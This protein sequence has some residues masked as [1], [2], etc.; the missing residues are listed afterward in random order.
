MTVL[1][2]RGCWSYTA[3]GLV[4]SHGPVDAGLLHPHTVGAFWLF[5]AA[6]NLASATDNAT[7]GDSGFFDRAGLGCWHLPSCD[8]RPATW[9]WELELASERRTQGCWRV[10]TG[11]LLE[12]RSVLLFVPPKWIPSTAGT[13]GR[14]ETETANRHRSSQIDRRPQTTNVLDKLAKPSHARREGRH[15]LWATCLLVRL[16]V[17]RP[18]STSA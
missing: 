10:V 1:R 8:M 18:A 11:T 14:A 13:G 5:A 16:R 7:Q 15:F 9:T 12:P 17:L 4:P 2:R 6:A 3:G